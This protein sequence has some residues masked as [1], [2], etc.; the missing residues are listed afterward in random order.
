ME[1]YCCSIS[2]E[3]A[4]EIDRQTRLSSLVRFYFRLKKWQDYYHGRAYK[5]AGIRIYLHRNK[6]KR[7]PYEHFFRYFQNKVKF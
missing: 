3:R 2:E 7:K 6:S 5:N 1:L 4:V